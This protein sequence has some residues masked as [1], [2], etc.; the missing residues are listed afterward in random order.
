MNFMFKNCEEQQHKLLRLLLVLECALFPMKSKLPTIEPE[1]TVQVDLVIFKRQG[2]KNQVI[3]LSYN[4]FTYKKT[5]D[6]FKFG[7]MF[8]KNTYFQPHILEIA[9]KKTAYNRK[10]Q[11]TA[12]GPHLA[13]KDHIFSFKLAFL[14]GIWPARHLKRYNEARGQIQLPAPGI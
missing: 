2:P 9:D 1:K 7:N 6:G 5:N 4:E 3:R 10:G 12:R 11:H 8:L 13:R 14:T